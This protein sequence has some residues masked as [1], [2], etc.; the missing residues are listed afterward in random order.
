LNFSHHT[1]FIKTK[2][3]EISVYLTITNQCFS[4]THS[5][6]PLCAAGC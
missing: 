6:L 4:K 1:C 5:F 2:T 3:A